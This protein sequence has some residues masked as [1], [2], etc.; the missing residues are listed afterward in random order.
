MIQQSS[1]TRKYDRTRK[2]L[3]KLFEYQDCRGEVGIRPGDKAG[4]AWCRERGVPLDSHEAKKYA[5][6][7]L[8]RYSVRPWPDPY[9]LFWPS[10]GKLGF[11]ADP[12]FAHAWEAMIDRVPD[13][14]AQ[15]LSRVKL[16]EK[17]RETPD[18]QCLIEHHGRYGWLCPDCERR[19]RLLYLPVRTCTL[20][21]YYGVK[22]PGLRLP[23]WEQRLLCAACHRV[24]TAVTR[25]RRGPWNSYVTAVTA[26]LLYGSEVRQ[27]AWLERLVSP[28][29]G[30]DGR[31]KAHLI[32]PKEAP[33]RNLA[34]LLFR[35]GKTYTE[36][37]RHLGIARRSVA[38]MISQARL[39]LGLR[40][41]R[42]GNP[43]LARRH[44]PPPTASAAGSPDLPARPDSSCG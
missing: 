26:G 23:T 15:R 8:T 21:E 36:I 6:M 16:D 22:I 37:A 4:E 9:R 18:G 19:V 2:T 5:Q 7:G 43:A 31:R 14:F 24:D 38:P 44:Q 34:W 13:E 33:R 39:P 25:A 30:K 17:D 28:G 35:Q 20:P 1:R 27:P 32:P 11:V 10:A 41:G 29:T 3:R 40:P 42:T 12:V